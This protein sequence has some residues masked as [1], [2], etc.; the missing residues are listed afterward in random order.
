MQIPPGAVIKTFTGAER[1]TKLEELLKNPNHYETYMALSPD[2]QALYY[3]A[4][5]DGELHLLI[6]A[7]GFA[8]VAESLSEQ[9]FTVIDQREDEVVPSSSQMRKGL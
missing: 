3:P 2:L 5:V 7:E 9:G 1:E 8:E 6:K 4:E